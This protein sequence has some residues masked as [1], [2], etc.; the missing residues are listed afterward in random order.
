VVVDPTIN[1]DVMELYADPA[2]RGG[3]L[4]A[5]GTVSVK[6]RNGDVVKAAHRLDPVLQK[7]DA[8]LEQVD[9]TGMSDERRQEIAA[10]INAR[11][12]ALM[13]VYT[14]VAEHFADLHDTPG[15]MQSKGCIRKVVPWNRAREF[16]FWRL[17]RRL[18]E[19]VLCSQIAKASGGMSVG[20]SRELLNK[21]FAEGMV[22]Q[23][24]EL[25][26]S[27]SLAEGDSA[28]LTAQLLR[29]INN[30]ADPKSVVPEKKELVKK[31][32][33][34][35][36]VLSWMDGDQETI[37][38]RI[39]GLTKQR[40]SREVVKLGVEEPEATIDGLLNMLNKLTP[41][42]R[43]DALM[44]IRKGVLLRCDGQ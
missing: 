31:W 33:D 4:E 43:K 12:Q 37:K 15:R 38:G 25:G 39:S 28:G 24:E 5:A 41:T 27:K 26:T 40:V 36:T 7:L 16:F 1:P 44:T 29:M 13:T 35:R 9:S 20:E 21:W 6:F 34:D 22:A 32:E 18:H 8:E 19:N 10:Q 17:K 3:V 30:S 2:G 11:E 14:Q 42:Q 23:E